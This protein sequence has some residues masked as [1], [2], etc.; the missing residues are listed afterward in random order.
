[1]TDITW[2]GPTSGLS[3]L[4]Q[5]IAKLDDTDMLV[6]TQEERRLISVYIDQLEDENQRIKSKYAE[7]ALKSHSARKFMRRLA[8]EET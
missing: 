3:P 7:I 8:G 4:R 2:I 6:I 5:A 1:M